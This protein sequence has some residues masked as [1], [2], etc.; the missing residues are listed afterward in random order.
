MKDKR[1]P[2]AAIS[3]NFR[4]VTLTVNVFFKQVTH[5][6]ILPRERVYSYVHMYTVLLDCA[7]THCTLMYA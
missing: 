3:Q 2:I 4:P 7:C 1:D 5:K 6:S